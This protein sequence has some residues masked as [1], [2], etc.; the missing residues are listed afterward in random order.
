MDIVIKYPWGLFRIF[1]NKLRDEIGFLYLRG[2]SELEQNAWRLYALA[3]YSI[4]GQDF[5]KTIFKN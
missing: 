1:N 2:G 3:L 5:P 4:H